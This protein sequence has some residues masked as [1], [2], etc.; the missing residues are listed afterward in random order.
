MLLNTEQESYTVIIIIIENT[1]YHRPCTA[2]P[3][4]TKFQ[5]IKNISAV[6]HKKPN[7]T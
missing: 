3:R 5:K 4:P 1:R 6:L 2:L 7:V